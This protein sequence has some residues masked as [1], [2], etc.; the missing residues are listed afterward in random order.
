MSEK[1]IKQI[2]G[3]LTEAKVK[4]QRRKD[5][6][7]M[8]EIMALVKLNV[9]VIDKALEIY[10]VTVDGKEVGTVQKGER[11]HYYRQGGG[12]GGEKLSMI[13][14][15][16]FSAK[17]VNDVVQTNIGDTRKDA[18]GGYLARKFDNDTN[19]KREILKR[20]GEIDE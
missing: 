13:K 2:D 6:L 9:K 11:Q 12:A 15:W 3:V 17:D 1:L 4:K 16:T 7:S 18:I 10:K 14:Q 20:K 5:I 19:F 8:S